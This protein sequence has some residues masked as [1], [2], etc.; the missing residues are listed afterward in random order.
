MVESK[1]KRPKEA[2]QI[3]KIHKKKR[4]NGRQI[5]FGSGMR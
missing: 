4:N 2:T 3:L 1:E 5:T